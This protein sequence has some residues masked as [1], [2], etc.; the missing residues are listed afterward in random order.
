MLR[1]LNAILW[2]L[3]ISPSRFSFGITASLR[4]SGRV[5]LPLIPV[6]RSSGP[7]LTPGIPFS[8]M[9]AVKCSPSTFA[10]VM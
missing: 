1:M 3:P 10:N 4:I 8:M 6:L 9:N 5:E 2:P 7:T